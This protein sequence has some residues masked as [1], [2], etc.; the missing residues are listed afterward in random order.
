MTSHRRVGGVRADRRRF[1]KQSLAT[2]GALAA[3]VVVPG[4]VLG[5]DGATAPSNRINMGFVGLG[6]QGGGVL[7]HASMYYFSNPPAGR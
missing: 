4:I 6:G 1:L 7:A 5:K 2:A 3:P